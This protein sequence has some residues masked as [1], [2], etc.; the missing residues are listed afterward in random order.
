MILVTGAGG[1]SGGVITR[2]ALQAGHDVTAYVGRRPSL[3]ASEGRLAVLPGDLLD[4]TQV[5]PD[6]FD[7]IIHC[8]ASSP[9]PTRVMD[10]EHDND[11]V[12]FRLSRLAVQAKCRL[13]IYLSS[14]SVYGVVSTPALSEAN[15]I[16]A[17][18]A[19]GIT[20]YRGETHLQ[21]IAA[22]VPSIALRLP[23]VVGPGAARNWPSRVKAAHKAGR[24]L[25]VF[26]PDAAFNNALHVDD[27][28]KFCLASVDSLGTFAAGSHAVNLAAAGKTSVRGAAELIAPGLTIYENKA[29]ERTSFTISIAKVRSVYG[30][31]PMT[32]EKTLRQYAN[33]G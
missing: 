23:A 18:D 6:Q 1:F 8:A 9:E 22:A 3:L 15:P 2:R 17:T 19:Y 29:P 33:E 13:F 24:P 30:F 16:L 32:I 20:K 5:F 14:V 28:A 27:L 26:N 4:P 10:Y 21:E 25:A 12:T 31:A 7:A 11:A